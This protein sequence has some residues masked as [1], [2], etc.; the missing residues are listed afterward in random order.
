MATRTKVTDRFTITAGN[1]DMY[2]IVQKTEYAVMHT[3]SGEL[4]RA[5]K[6]WLETEQGHKVNA[7]G[8]GR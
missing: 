4:E 3:V 8:D 5:G 7:H 6:V 2:R 1:G